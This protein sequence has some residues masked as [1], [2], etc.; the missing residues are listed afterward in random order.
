MS[1]GV[2]SFGAGSLGTPFDG[3][4]VAGSVT[5][6]FT[7]TTDSPSVAMAANV[8]SIYSYRIAVIGDSNASGRGTN[9]QSAP[10]SG[11]FLYNNSGNVVALADPWD[12]GPNT[13]SSLDDGVSA[14]GSFV[15]GMANSFFS[16]GKTSLWVPANKGGTTTANWSRSLSTATCYG[17]MKARI[18]AAGGVDKIVICLGANDAIGAVA[19]A[20]FVAQMNQLIANLTSDFPGTEIYLQKIHNFSGYGAQVTAIRAG[21]QEVWDGVSGV[22]KGADL[23]GITTSVHYTTNGELAAVAS[24][25][26][27][28]INNP[29]AVTFAVTAD[30]PSFSLAASVATASG[31]ITT[32]VL[33]N[34]TGTVLASETG[35]TVNV[36]NATTGTLIVQKTGLT[37]NGSGVITITDAL[38]VSGTSY[39]FEPI[40][41]GSRRRL[42]VVAAT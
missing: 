29:P 28:A 22:K 4:I 39:A 10:A 24:R 14:M 16:A 42:P 23:D 13:Y 31:T 15:P 27:S 19:Q 18:D 40:L 17:A 9:N 6:Q 34:N 36:Y 12:A 2:N 38:I 30:S 1:Y 26:Y 11:A 37:S 35:I 20:T 41:S 25:T 5:A 7:V 3:V 33:K 8:A 32:P 21:V